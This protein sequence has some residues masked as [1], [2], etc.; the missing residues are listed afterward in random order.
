MDKKFNL[1]KVLVLILGSFI[2]LSSSC[3]A[4]WTQVDFKDSK[5]HVYI[6]TKVQKSMELGRSVKFPL[7]INLHGCAQKAETLKEFGN[8]EDAANEFSTFIVLPS[9]PD[10]G[11]YAGCWD[12]Y[13]LGHSR[14]TGHSGYLIE[15]VEFLNKLYPVEK[16][17]IFLSGL[18]SG[19][20]ETMVMACLAPELIA[21]VGVNAAPSVGTSA[22]QTTR[23]KISVEEIVKNCEKLAGKNKRY[24]KNLVVSIIYGDNDFIVDTDYNDL[25]RQAFAQILETD[26]SVAMEMSRLPG[27]KVEGK[28]T[29]YYRKNKLVLSLIE[30]KGIGHAWPA[31]TGGDKDDYIARDSVNYPL[32]LLNFLITNN[33]RL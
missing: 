20:G 16:R 26:S 2:G 30:N 22:F 10:G 9:A 17:S 11:V 5:L 24:L 33:Q 12:Y 15:L 1:S 4:A 19:G 31:G 25:N 6:P 29:L 28:G 3:F 21:G 27:S 7:M 23:A 13:G 18:S 32:Y 14:S 8:W